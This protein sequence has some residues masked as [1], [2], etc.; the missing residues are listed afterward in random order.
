MI[1]LDQLG[2]VD[3]KAFLRESCDAFVDGEGYFGSTNTDTGDPEES[4]SFAL[5]FQTLLDVSEYLGKP[6]YR[7]FAYDVCLPGLQRFWIPEDLNGQATKGLLR[8]SDSYSSACMWECSEAALAYLRAAQDAGDPANILIAL[9]ILRG[10]ARNHFGALGFVPSELDWDGRI[11]PAGHLQPGLYGPRAVTH[12]YMNN[13]HIV[14]PTLFYLE[15][16]AWKVRQ[17]GSES[18][19]DSQGNRLWPTS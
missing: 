19:L 10:I 6:E 13:L 2:H 12:P 7:A 17:N 11:H 18:I 3:A 15:K 9:T 4:V 8:L 14:S 16:L 1:R 5:A